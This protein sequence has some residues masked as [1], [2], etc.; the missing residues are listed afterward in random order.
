MFTHDLDYR[1]DFPS[2]TTKNGRL[3]QIEGRQYPSITTVLGSETKDQIERWKERVGQRTA[4]KIVKEAVDRGS[5]VH[6]MIETF[7][8]NEVVD[9]SKYATSHVAAFNKIKMFLKRINNILCL[10]NVL[11]S[12]ILEVAGR[13]D[14]IAEYDGELAVIDFKTST[15]SNKTD[16]MIEDYFIQA[17]AYSFMFAELFDIEISKIVILMSTDNGLPLV[18]VKDARDYYEKLVTKVENFNAKR[19]DQLARIRST[20]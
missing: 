3:Y 8:N 9:V 1:L 16:T 7:L 2:V 15:S 4:E 18:F 10:E 19:A 20:N 13:V 11:F 6:E 12:D 14:C 17:S 5:A